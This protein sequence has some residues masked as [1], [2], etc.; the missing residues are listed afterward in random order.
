MEPGFRQAF[1]LRRGLCSPHDYS[2]SCT[3]LAALPA[4]G[5]L[6]GDEFPIV[7]IRPKQ[8]LWLLR[9]RFLEVM[10]DSVRVVGH[11]YRG[12]GTGVFD[13]LSPDGP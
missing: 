10:P 6:I 12:R 5:P 4:T 1:G 13:K 2:A 3:S 11:P 9:S 7:D 8:L